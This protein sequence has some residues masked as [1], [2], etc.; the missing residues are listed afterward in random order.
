M[1]AQESRLP[2]PPWKLPPSK[3]QDFF[4]IYPSLGS[5]AS[6]LMIDNGHEWKSEKLEL[7]KAKDKKK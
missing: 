2:Y 6:E 1:R 3:F 5:Q 7:Q 4:K